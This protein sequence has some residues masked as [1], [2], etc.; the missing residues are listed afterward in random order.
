MAFAAPFDRIDPTHRLVVR[1]PSAAAESDRPDP[2]AVENR[3]VEIAMD[4][5]DAVHC[6]L[7]RSFLDAADPARTKA[8]NRLHRVRESD[9]VLASGEPEYRAA[10]PADRDAVRAYL[11]VD[12]ENTDA[13]LARVF[14]IAEFAIITDDSWLYRSVPHHDHIREL[15]ANAVDGFL[16]DVTASLES[17]PGSGVVPFDGLGTWQTEE[18]RYAVTAR[19]IR[20][21]TDGDRWQTFDLDRL[22]AVSL[23]PERSELLLRW[24]SP[25]T[26]SWTRR[27]FR[28]VVGR[29]STE[30]PSRV[31]LPDRETTAE[32]AGALRE[33]ADRLEYE[34]TVEA[35][36]A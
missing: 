11:S 30:P 35:I 21:S 15:N 34:F 3:I 6:C 18:Y 13:W 5:A 33:V 16:D 1:S 10:L 12:R 24:D 20:R 23:V 31:S 9:R 26:D 25:A 22:R 8:C 7:D 36:D 4:S 27:A 19:S 17:I 28:T 14:G 2:L 32:F 29:G